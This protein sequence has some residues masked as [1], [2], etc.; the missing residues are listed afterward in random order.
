[1][2]STGNDKAPWGW[3]FPP[4]HHLLV[5][6]PLGNLGPGGPP[7]WRRRLGGRLRRRARHLSRVNRGA[8]HLGRVVGLA[9]DRCRVDRGAVDHGAVGGVVKRWLF[10]G[11]VQASLV[12]RLGS[13]RIVRRGTIAALVV[14]HGSPF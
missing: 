11:L 14:G 1:M 2:M 9:R 10:A 6:L 8:R 12:A 13:A 3:P 7:G 5:V 4:G